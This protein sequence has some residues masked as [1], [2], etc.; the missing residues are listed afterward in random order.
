MTNNAEASLQD[1]IDAAVQRQAAQYIHLVALS[2]SA[3]RI[4]GC[5][6]VQG[7]PQMIVWDTLSHLPQDCRLFTKRTYT[8][9]VPVY[10]FARLDIS[11]VAIR[12]L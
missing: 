12:Q 1:A 11:S 6:Y 7:I 3:S 10:V 2:V 4:Q 8:W 9:T 5:S